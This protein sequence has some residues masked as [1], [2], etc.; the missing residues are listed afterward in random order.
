MIEIYFTDTVTVTRVT[1][2]KWGAETTSTESLRCRVERKEKWVKQDGGA[3]KVSLCQVIYSPTF[4]LGMKDRVT[5]D[6]VALPIMEIA[7][8]KDWLVV[9][10]EARLG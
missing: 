10:K 2:D 6:G 4:S 9:S 5:V 7:E 3:M 1:K 8:N